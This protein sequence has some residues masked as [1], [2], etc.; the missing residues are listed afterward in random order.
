MHKNNVKGMSLVYVML[1]LIIIGFTTTALIKLSHKNAMTQIQYSNSESARLAVKAGFDNALSF[2]ETTDEDDQKKVL[3]ALQ[4][5]MTIN[6]DEQI[7]DPWLLGS[8]N[9]TI[10]LDANCNYKVKVLGFDPKTFALSLQSTGEGAGT[11]KASAIGTYIIDGLGYKVVEKNNWENENALYL[12]DGISFTMHGPL[13]IDGACY[14]GT[15]VNLDAGCSGSIFKGVFRT[16]VSSTAQFLIR[17]EYTFNGPAYFGMRQYTDGN[18]KLTF[19]EK[20]G[21][22][23]GLK[24]VGTNEIKMNMNSYWNQGPA[25][26]G[27]GIIDMSNKNLV[28]HSTY[29]TS[30]IGIA[31]KN[32]VKK[33][34]DSELDIPDSLTIGTSICEINVN[35]DVIDDN[36]IMDFSDFDDSLSGGSHTLNG[37]IANQL[38]DYAKQNNMLWHDFAVLNIDETVNIEDDDV[39]FKNKMIVIV[40]SGGKLQPNN[41]GGC[42]D[43]DSTANFSVFSVGSG[44]VQ[45]IGGWEY[46]RSF[47]FCDS[48]STF[49]VGGS[50]NETDNI[51]G[52]IHAQGNAS[53]Q[54]YPAFDGN[55]FIKYDKT[56]LEE[57]SYDDFI[58]LSDNCNDSVSTSIDSTTLVFKEASLTTEL[59]SRSF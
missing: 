26:S 25:S 2:L 8:E 19:N 36:L 6:E 12:G 9:S 1:C 39:N 54:W 38:Y 15:G 57:L 20:A 48:S 45:N 24:W 50:Q 42:F 35:I 30:G 21:F 52:A 34:I 28:H 51:H 46:F 5:W 3:A 31:T 27:G 10:S 40:P 53:V 16:G 49:V 47:M 11:G 23:Y 18:M 59:L 33:T 14:F 58:T 13:E 22:E 7:A 29:N 4:K 32:Y 43:T 44:N 37:K 41:T 55:A 56:V 17:G